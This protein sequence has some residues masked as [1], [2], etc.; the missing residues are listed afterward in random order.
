MLKYKI[1]SG[2]TQHQIPILINNDIDNMGIMIGFD[3]E[4]SQIEQYC[5]F[6]YNGSGNTLT[7]YNSIN[8]NKLQTLI[9]SIFQ[10]SWGDGTIDELDMTTIYDIN[11]P[12]I[13]HTFIS[14]GTYEIVIDVISPWKRQ[15][16]IRNIEIP[17]INS[18]GFPTNFGTLTFTVPYVTPTVLIDQDYLQD[19]RELTGST[20]NT[21]ISFMGV[22]KSRLN[23]FKMYGTTNVYSGITI[24]TGETGTYTGYTIDNLYYMDYDDGYTYITGTT[25]NYYKEEVYDG[26]LTRNEHLIGFIDLPIISSDIFV[27]RGRQ[28]VMERNIRL[29]EIDSVGELD[30]YGSKF[31][32]IKKQ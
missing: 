6:T 30:I 28:G 12:N 10:I 4:I 17:F 20:N 22:G 24:S 27:D 5:N 7:I 32:K 2:T 8:T 29:S 3:G 19:Y 15:K 21:N 16:I 26:M 14:G 23:E 18:F 31:Y 1:L 9:N 13:S 25:S 11:L